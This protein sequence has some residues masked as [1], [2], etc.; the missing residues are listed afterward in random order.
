MEGGGKRWDPQA[1]GRNQ[2]PMFLEIRQNDLD[3][4][5]WPRN[6][7]K[8]SEQKCRLEG[9]AG[10]EMTHGDA[11]WADQGCTAVSKGTA[12]FFQAQGKEEEI[13]TQCPQGRIRVL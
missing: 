12:P 10:L 6:H 5:L 4:I 7:S 8:K 3:T 2:E 11:H 9:M 1:V 13:T